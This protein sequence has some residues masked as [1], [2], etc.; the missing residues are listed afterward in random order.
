ME[1]NIFGRKY[2]SALERMAWRSDSQSSLS[3]R[4]HDREERQTM[5]SHDGTSSRGRSCLVDL[6]IEMTKAIKPRLAERRRLSCPANSI[7]S[8]L[9]IPQTYAAKHWLVELFGNVL[10]H[11]PSQIYAISQ[12]IHILI[13]RYLK[14]KK[15]DLL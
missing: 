11:S 6:G 2:L 10:Q 7:C 8:L 1:T 3:G 4:V 5:A 13:A 14:K 12:K 9:R 15:K